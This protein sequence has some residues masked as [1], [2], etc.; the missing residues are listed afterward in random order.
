MNKLDKKW[1]LYIHLCYSYACMAD[2][3][4]ENWQGIKEQLQANRE[5]YIKD[6]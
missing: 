6:Y 1:E 4:Y 3:S 2:I 5:D